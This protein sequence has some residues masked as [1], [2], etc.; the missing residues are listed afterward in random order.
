MQ[1]KNKHFGKGKMEDFKV[2]KDKK[3]RRKE[4]R[5]NKNIKNWHIEE[6][7]DSY[8]FNVTYDEGEDEKIDKY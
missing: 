1:E 7:E 5:Q 2:K 3:I 8:D 4:R 6:I